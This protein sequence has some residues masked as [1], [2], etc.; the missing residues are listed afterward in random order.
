MNVLNVEPK[1]KVKSSQHKDAEDAKEKLKGFQELIQVGL[2]LCA[3][4][5]LCV[6]IF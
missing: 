1:I 3:L 5:A 6:E 2:F 4:C